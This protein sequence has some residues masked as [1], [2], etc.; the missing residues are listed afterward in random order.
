[1]RREWGDTVVDYD[2]GWCSVEVGMIQNSCLVVDEVNVDVVVPDF[3]VD[4]AMFVVTAFDSLERNTHVEK[5]ADSVVGYDPYS[6]E[7][8]ELHFPLLHCV[9]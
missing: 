7:A 8:M 9:S 2:V 1:M 4:I 3:V 6:E 5:F